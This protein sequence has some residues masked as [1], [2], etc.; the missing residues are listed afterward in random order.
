LLFGGERRE[1]VTDLVA[2]AEIEGVEELLAGGGEGDGALAAIGFGG[3]TA[4]ELRAGEAL[5]DAAEVAYVEAKVCG[6][7]GGSGLGAVGEF[8]EDTGLGEG[9][10]AFQEMFVEGAEETC[11]EAVEA[12]DCGNGGCV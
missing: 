5:K 11:I 10:G 3:L 8:V 4:D 12:A 1:K 9:E 6:D 7:R 2:G